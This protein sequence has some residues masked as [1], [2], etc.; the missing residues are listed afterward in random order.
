MGSVADAQMAIKHGADA[1]GMV[2]EQPSGP[3]VIDDDLAREIASTIPPGVESFL[4]T[5]RT[6]ADAIADHA[7]YVGTSTIQIVQHIDVGEYPRLIN[8]LPN[9]RRVQVIH[10]EDASA[11][12]LIDVYAPYVHA[13]L[14]DSGRPGAAVAEFGGTGRV[15]DWDISAEFVRRSPIPVYLAGGLKPDNIADAIARVAPFG[16]DLCSGVRDGR[17]LDEDLLAQFV[18]GV[19]GG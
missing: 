12:E 3:G 7:A 13:F 1:V 19:W 8:K 11:L 16:V 4:L 17:R 10:V 6:S 18:R 9:V 15:H 2:G 14:L 5:S